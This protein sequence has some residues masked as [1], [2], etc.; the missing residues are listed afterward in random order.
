MSFTTLALITVLLMLG[1]YLYWITAN[2]SYDS[3]AYAILLSRAVYFGEFKALWNHYH[4]LYL[5]LCYLVSHAILLISPQPVSLIY[6]MQI[7]NAL[8]TGVYL[9]IFAR[10]LYSLIK[11]KVFALLFTVILGF[12][13]S[14]WYYSTNPEVYPPVML[15]Y[16]TT[17]VLTIQG[18]RKPGWTMLIIISIFAGIATAFHAAA[19]LLFPVIALTF[20][21]QGL[22]KDTL[23]QRVKTVCVMSLLFLITAFLPY[24]LYYRYGENTTL[25]SGLV[26]TVATVAVDDVD[27]HKWFLH[28]GIEPIVEI[29]GLL[30]NF[31]ENPIAPSP[32]FKVGA[33]L[34]RAFLAI[35]LLMALWRVQSLWKTHGWPV[36]ALFGWFTLFF[37]FFSSYGVGS[38][39]Y[40]TFLHIP[41]L[42]LGAMAW[43][44]IRRPRVIYPI[45]G[46]ITLLLFLNNIPIII[47][48]SRLEQNV[49]YQKAMFIHDHTE[50]DDLVVHL[51]IG[52][53][54]YQKVYLPYFGM[55]QE[56]IIDF[57][58]QRNNF[59]REQIV[60]ELN[61]TITMRWN[62][63][64][65]VF[66]LSQ[67]L[68]NTS[69]VQN[70]LTNR[71]LAPDFLQNYFASF[72]MELAGTYN[73]EFK[74]Y[75][76]VPKNR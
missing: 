12:S 63:G 37:L 4:I 3:V 17:I 10:F 23:W 6:V 61:Q 41:L 11:D 1:I 28:Q 59:S 47:A 64:A 58:I 49:H 34:V 48:H 9:F 21:L 53:D 43:A 7:V 14:V 38:I 74:L 2:Y 26:N 18:L 16:I 31:A 15:C 8:A 45:L 67:V 62:S 72:P 25:V 51:G 68:E 54:T 22:T 75:R 60:Q 46:V 20:F 57:L 13:F 65:D 76:L 69:L 70:F 33:Y 66:L 42:I 39:K 50:Q 19:G 30:T 32:L 52:E 71:Q 24:Y 44:E 40:V 56:L 27:G 35:C 73:D 29:K 55:R 36:A 5:P